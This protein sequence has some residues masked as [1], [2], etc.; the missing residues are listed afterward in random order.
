ME[1]F[2]SRAILQ[3]RD[4]R[5]KTFHDR[6]AKAR[7]NT[8]WHVEPRSGT[9]GAHACMRHGA[10]NRYRE[11]KAVASEK[12]NHFSPRWNRTSGAGLR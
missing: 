12:E 3:H 6:K 10:R 5:W 1:V 11:R 8:W 4:S 9:G 2:K 7:L